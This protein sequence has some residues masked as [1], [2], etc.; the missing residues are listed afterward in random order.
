MDAILQGENVGARTRQTS[1]PKQFPTNIS[2]KI[3]HPC[4][5]HVLQTN[6]KNWSTL[7]TPVSDNGTIRLPPR[8]QLSPMSIFVFYRIS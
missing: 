8:R 7:Y 2:V 5:V 4:F 1:L 3:T 6:I